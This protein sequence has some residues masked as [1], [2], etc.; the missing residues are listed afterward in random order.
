MSTFIG[1]IFRKRDK[2]ATTSEVERAFPGDGVGFPV[3]YTGE[4]ILVTNDLLSRCKTLAEHSGAFRLNDSVVLKPG[5]AAHMSEASAMRLVRERTSIPA[6]RVLDAYEQETDSR[7]VI[8]MEYVK[9][10]TL[11]KAWPGLDEEQKRSVLSELK[12]HMGELRDISGTFIGNVDNGP[13]RDQFFAHDK[14]IGSFAPGDSDSGTHFHRALA[15]EVRGRGDNSWHHVVAR[16]IESLPGGDVVMTHNDL[17]PRNILVREDKVVAI[18]DWEMSGF[19]PD[20][21]EY[22]KA[23]LWNDWQSPWINEGLPD[24]I[25]EPRMQELAYLLHA[26]DIFR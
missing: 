24:R 3:P 26:R 22:V 9:G 8:L 13:C 20:Y 4:R 18:L 2:Q 10:E 1:K 5:E 6:P 17:A 19:Y 25:L 23:Y 14:S 15:D 21:W 16:F 11:D 12:Q 7:G